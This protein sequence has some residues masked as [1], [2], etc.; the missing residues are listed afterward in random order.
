M[1]SLA[2]EPDMGGAPWLCRASGAAVQ[3]G[4][5]HSR[6]HLL[7]PLLLPPAAQTSHTFFDVHDNRLV[8][9]VGVQ[10]FEPWTR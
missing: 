10:G 3:S 4:E 2:T 7:L 5:G 1:T 9:L 6:K 8:S